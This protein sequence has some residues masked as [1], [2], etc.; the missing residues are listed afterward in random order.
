MTY[1]EWS[2]IGVECIVEETVVDGKIDRRMYLW[3][4]RYWRWCGTTLGL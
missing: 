1:V 4:C 3:T 2:E